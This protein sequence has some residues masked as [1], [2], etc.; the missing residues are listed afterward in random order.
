MLFLWLQLPKAIK[1]QDFFKKELVNL[2]NY[3]KI[4]PENKNKQSL[5]MPGRVNQTNSES[6]LSSLG[7]TAV[8]LI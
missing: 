8:E 4:T 5:P 6:S 2:P 7:H 3:Q 1:S